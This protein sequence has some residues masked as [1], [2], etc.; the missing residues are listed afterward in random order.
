V[1]R[2]CLVSVSLV[3]IN[4]KGSP[5][6]KKQTSWPAFDRSSAGKLAFYLSDL[7]HVFGRDALADRHCAFD[8]AYGGDVVDGHFG[9]DL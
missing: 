7:G 9:V 1:C 2:R 3:F 6:K 8:V 5:P 4:D